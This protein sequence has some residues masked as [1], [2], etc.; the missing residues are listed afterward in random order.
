MSEDFPFFPPLDVSEFANEFSFL[1]KPLVLDSI[2][3]F[4]TACCNRLTW[5]CLVERLPL[6]PFESL[7]LLTVRG[8]K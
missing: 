8:I 1:F 2:I 3:L 5:P 7:S 4:R 6:D